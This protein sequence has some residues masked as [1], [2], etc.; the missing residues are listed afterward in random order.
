MTI[1]EALLLIGLAFIAVCLM[2]AGAIFKNQFWAISAM[3]AWLLVCGLGF[4]TSLMAWDLYYFLGWFGLA[5]TF[6]SG[7]EAVMI[8]RSQK[9]TDKEPEE[10]RPRTFKEH[11]NNVKASRRRKAER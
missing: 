10:Q 8:R 1:A 9:F 11:L 5:M 4:I 3:P 7:M 2:M 6:G